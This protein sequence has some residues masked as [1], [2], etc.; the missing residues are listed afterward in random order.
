MGCVG[1]CVCTLGQWSPILPYQIPC[2]APVLLSVTLS[3]CSHI[4]QYFQL[5]LILCD[6]IHSFQLQ[7]VLRLQRHHALWL[8]YDTAQI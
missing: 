6:N 3:F 7:K 2:P 4:F 8:I 5:H 1:N